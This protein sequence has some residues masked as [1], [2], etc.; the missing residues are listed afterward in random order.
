MKKKL[1]II[2]FLLLILATAVFVSYMAV[3]SYRHEMD[4]KTGD[5]IFGGAVVFLAVII[6][7]FIIWYELDLFYTVYYFFVKPKTLLKS[8]INILAILSFTF[9]LVCFLSDALFVALGRNEKI[10]LYAFL[11]YIILRTVNLLVCAFS[12]KTE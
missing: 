9:V 11:A 7:G 3:E 8:T 2:T 12:D 10:V 5:D 4:P 1:I 6:G